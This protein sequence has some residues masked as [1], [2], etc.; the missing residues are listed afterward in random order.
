MIQQL[1]SS[2]Y[3]RRPLPEI[4]RLDDGCGDL[5][6]PFLGLG[7]QVSWT[8]ADNPPS[9]YGDGGV[10][11]VPTSHLSLEEADFIVSAGNGV[12]DLEGFHRLADILGAGVGA[13]RVAV[14]DGRLTREQQVGATGKS[15]D[16]SVNIALGSSEDVQRLDRKKKH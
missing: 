7:E 8:P 6:L 12:H 9:Q 5:R 15:V 13:S 1:P 11:A 10:T 14:D 16:S 2:V 4:I 3:D